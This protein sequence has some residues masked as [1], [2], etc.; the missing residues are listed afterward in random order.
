MWSKVGE[1]SFKNSWWARG[2]S[3]GFVLTG[4]WKTWVGVQKHVFYGGGYF[5]VLKVLH[6][7]VDT[8]S[9]QREKEREEREE[10][11]KR[12]HSRRP[13]RLLMKGEA[14]DV[15][16][17]GVTGRYTHSAPPA[18]WVPLERYTNT[19][20]SSNTRDQIFDLNWQT[21]WLHLVVGTSQDKHVRLY[22]L[23]S[24]PKHLGK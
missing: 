21:Q 11:V 13:L 1:I 17:D 12:K 10:V 14:C 4:G 9:P 15:W 18:S 24:K 3:F 8:A 2:F 22:S 6:V 23:E 7:R 5:C 16:E 20:K 19:H